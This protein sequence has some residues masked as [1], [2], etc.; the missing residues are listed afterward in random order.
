MSWGYKFRYDGTLEDLLPVLNS[1]PWLWAMHDS[2]PQGFYLQARDD[3][4]RL[5]V[6]KPSTFLLPYR[7]ADQQGFHTAQ[8]DF[9][10]TCTMNW[11][12]VDRAVRELLTT[13]GARQIEDNDP[14]L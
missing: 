7:G 9:D 6:H 14:Y 12:D 4:L 2:E 10:S 13:A 1:G 8:V 11:K 3:G 5:R